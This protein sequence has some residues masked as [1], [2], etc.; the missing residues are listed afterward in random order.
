MA[1]INLKDTYSEVLCSDIDDTML[2]KSIPTTVFV[3]T[4][5]CSAVHA[6]YTGRFRLET[7]KA[8]EV[9]DRL[10]GYLRLIFDNLRHEEPDP[11]MEEEL[12][13]KIPETYQRSRIKSLISEV[14]SKVEEGA[15]LHIGARAS[16]RHKFRDYISAAYD[17]LLIKDR[18]AILYRLSRSREANPDLFGV[19]MYCL[20]IL[21]SRD[22]DA[23]AY[24][25][26][27]VSNK[28]RKKVFSLSKSDL[29]EPPSESI[30]RLMTLMSLNKI[31]KGKACETCI[32]A[33]YCPVL[34]EIVNKEVD[35]AEDIRS[36]IGQ[37]GGKL[38]E[39]S[40]DVE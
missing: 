5:K 16:L 10:M 15:A 30:L 9:K 17:L 1:V 35:N 11:F 36:D 25:S 32:H 13:E 37:T 14:N 19:L 2:K 39:L 31:N 18:D 20:L 12:L 24:V 21:H 38:T 29:K 33:R 7:R 40:G 34:K 23:V 28:G 22:V 26:Y 6:Q 4:T 27:S 3:L 8:M